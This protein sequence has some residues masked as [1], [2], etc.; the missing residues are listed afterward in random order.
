M[1]IVP[2]QQGETVTED[3]EQTIVKNGG[4]KETDDISNIQ[5][6]DKATY[7]ALTADE[8]ALYVKYNPSLTS[9][10]Y[11]QWLNAQNELIEAFN[12]LGPALQK[13]PDIEQLLNLQSAIDSI[14]KMAKAFAEIPDQVSSIASAAGKV[15]LGALT[16]IFTNI[17]KGVGALAAILYTMARNPYMMAKEYT[18]AF[19]SIDTASI[20]EYFEGET[21]PNLE[22]AQTK[23]DE[24]VIPDKEIKEYVDNNKNKVSSA[25]DKTKEVIETV[26]VMETTAKTAEAVQD[27]IDD[28]TLVL[29]IGTAEV[30]KKLV[31]DA[32]EEAYDANAKD[33]KEDAQGYANSVN[34]F[35]HNMPQKYIKISDLEKLKKY[36]ANAEETS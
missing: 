21:T 31:V 9:Q 7:N 17:L 30:A 16:D 22:V 2:N 18:E 4:E 6:I 36:Q 23:V 8:K 19:K 15:G 20:S 14:S 13:M 28:A 33:Y 32:Y 27:S 29:S 3:K 1:T 34:D 24:I 5:L 10:A 25:K 12:K 26:E 11:A 35:I